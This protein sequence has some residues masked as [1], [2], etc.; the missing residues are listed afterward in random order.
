MAL[1]G[2]ELMTAGITGSIAV[3]VT[4]N[5]VLPHR[6]VGGGIAAVWAVL[7]VYVG[8]VRNCEHVGIGVFRHL[9]TE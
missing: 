1:L 7:P 3:G 9:R 8:S 6:R 2:F 4:R 5:S